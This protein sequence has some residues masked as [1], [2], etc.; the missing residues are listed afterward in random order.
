M[1]RT[2]WA[3][4]S[5]LL[6]TVGLPHSPLWAGKGGLGRGMPRWP[7]IEAIIA[8]SSPQTKAPAPSMTSQLQ[9][10]ARAEERSSPRKPEPSGVFH[11]LAH[12]LDRQRVFRPD[13]DERL[14]GA[15]RPRGDHQ[16]FDHA[17][18]DCLP[19]RCGP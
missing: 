7:S 14:V 4:V 16:P 8:V 12:A 19:S 13:I 2:T 6:M 18:R 9:R 15:D 5:T 11:R 1:M 3:R 10:L 17:V